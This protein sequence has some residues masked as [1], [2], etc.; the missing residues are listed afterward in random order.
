MDTSETYSKMADCPEIQEEWRKR[1]YDKRRGDVYRDPWGRT[2][3]V[4]LSQQYDWNAVPKGSIWLPR[5]DQL[6]EM[7][8]N[9]GWGDDWKPALWPLHLAQVLDEYSSATYDYWQEICWQPESM[10][11]LWLAFV[12]AELHHKTWDGAGWA[13]APV[14]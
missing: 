13:K 8:P 11:Q 2:P 6:Q 10:E 12:M 1:R 4:G 14:K 7:V 9:E 3:C 5:Q